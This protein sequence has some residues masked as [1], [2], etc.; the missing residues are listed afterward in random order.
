MYKVFFNSG[1]DHRKEGNKFETIKW[2]PQ[3]QRIEIENYYTDV[4]KKVTY[5]GK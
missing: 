2:S 3:L 5:I 4:E 1:Q